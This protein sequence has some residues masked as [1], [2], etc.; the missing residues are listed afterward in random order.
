M[1]KARINN[2]KKFHDYIKSYGWR[3]KK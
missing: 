3:N 2:Y 1:T